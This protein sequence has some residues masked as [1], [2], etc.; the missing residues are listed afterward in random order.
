MSGPVAGTRAGAPVGGLVATI[1]V[2]AAWLAVALYFAAAVAPAAFRSLPSRT[3]AGSL[4]GNTLPAVFIAGVVAGIVVLALT[5]PQR[6]GT[7]GR[8]VRI[9]S[10]GLLAALCAAARLVMASID[11]LRGEVVGSLEAL[12]ASD[13][14][15][16]S[17]GRLHTVSVVLLA[18]AM[19]AALVTLV[20][21][22]RALVGGF[23]LHD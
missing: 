19:L 12:P 16:A 15:R 8:L 4:V 7:P 1:V 20:S 2:A 10:G 13:P 18:L 23:A 21:A 17:F 9:G 14:V 22:S 6:A 5:G 11:R 3:L